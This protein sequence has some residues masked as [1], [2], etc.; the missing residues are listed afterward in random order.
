MKP[1]ALTT[2]L[3]L[4]ASLS[5]CAESG[6][7]SGICQCTEG[8]TCI[9]GACEEARCPLTPCPQGLLC[10]EGYCIVDPSC[11]ED[12]QCPNGRCIE[13]ACYAQECEEEQTETIACGRCGTQERLCR[14]G[15]WVAQ[16]ACQAQGE[17]TAQ[18]QERG[19]C[20]MGLRT[21]QDDCSWGPWE[22][23]GDACQPDTTEEEACGN[24]GVRSRTCNTEC[25]WEEWETCDEEAGCTPGDTESQ[26]CGL[27]QGICTPGTQSRRCTVECI[28]DPWS[29]CDGSTPPQE[30]FCGD[31]IDQDCDGQD[32]EIPDAYEPNDS[33]ASAWYIGDDINPG[34]YF[35]LPI[36]FHGP[37]DNDDYFTFSWRDDLERPV[38]QGI[39]ATV[40]VPEGHKYQ[41]FLY[42]NR[43]D[44]QQNRPLDSS[45]RSNNGETF[46]LVSWSEDINA[47]PEQ[48]DSGNYYLRLRRIE[49]SSCEQ[50]GRFMRVQ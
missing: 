29:D 34:N 41:F 21:C 48:D 39:L 49:G 38:R 19:P 12:S 24:C 11:T 9:N 3:L 13:G 16:G 28:W 17:C 45:F 5:C 8:F 4:L 27:D 7:D 37:S 33:C 1:F 46:E 36:N 15:R 32:L 44:C 25:A 10:L 50:Q 31:G 14:E 22:E 23:R 35:D 47:D 6:I 40:D 2:L 43:S 18:A 26:A 42:R 30:E 20:G